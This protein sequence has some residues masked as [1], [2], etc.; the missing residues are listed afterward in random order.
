MAQDIVCNIEDDINVLLKVRAAR[1]GWSI[2]EEVRQI[3]LSAVSDEVPAYQNLGSRIA[4]RFAG[5]GLTKPLNE[6]RENIIKPMDFG[7]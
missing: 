6:F 2:E 3:L 5:V 4:A 7:S 1:H